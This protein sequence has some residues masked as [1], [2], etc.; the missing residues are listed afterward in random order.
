VVPHLLPEGASVTLA[1]VKVD[2]GQADNHLAMELSSRIPSPRGFPHVLVM[3]HL[4][5]VCSLSRGVMLSSDATPISPITGK[6]LLT[7]ASFTR[8]PISLPCGSLSQREDDGLTTFRASSNERV[9]SRLFA[10][11]T[12]SATGDFVAPVL[13]HMPFGSSLSAP[14]A[15][16]Q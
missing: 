11:G 16:S 4:L 5:E 3:R 1:F 12:T 7:P 14:L 2:S 9:R 15:C 6:P 10:G 13:G 8:S